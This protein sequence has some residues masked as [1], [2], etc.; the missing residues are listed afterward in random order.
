MN[1]LVQVAN[2]GDDIIESFTPS[3]DV[4]EL[5]EEVKHAMAQAE[6]NEQL[7]LAEIRMEA[8]K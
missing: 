1:D 7:R 6:K 3:A 4:L 2:P 8:A 5:N